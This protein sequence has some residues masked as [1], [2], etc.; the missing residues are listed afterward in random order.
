MSTKGETRQSL[1]LD[2]Y[3]FGAL[4][5]LLILLYVASLNEKCTVVSLCVLL[6][7]A[8]L[9]RNYLWP[10]LH[11]TTF[12]PAWAVCSVLVLLITFEIEVVPYLE[13]LVSDQHQ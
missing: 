13:I 2:N 10:N 5:I 11:Q 8:T 6:P 4:A 12:Y 1:A 9:L 7:L 3:A